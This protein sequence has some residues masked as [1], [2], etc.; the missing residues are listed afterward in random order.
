MKNL[1]LLYLVILKETLCTLYEIGSFS[2]SALDPIVAISVGRAHLTVVTSANSSGSKTVSLFNTTS[3]VSTVLTSNLLAPVKTIREINGLNILGS[4]YYLVYDTDGTVKSSNLSQ[5]NYSWLTMSPDNV[6]VANFGASPTIVYEL[7]TVGNDCKVQEVDTLTNS[8]VGIG[9]LYGVDCWE[10][11]YRNNII[12]VYVWDWICQEVAL[13]IFDALART[14][15]QETWYGNI[16]AYRNQKLE[17]SDSIFSIVNGPNMS[18][19]YTSNFSLLCNVLFNETIQDIKIT[20][21]WVYVSLSAEVR[22]YNP[23]SCMLFSI[24]VTTGPMRLFSQELTASS[25]YPRLLTWPLNSLSATVFNVYDRY[26]CSGGCTS[27]ITNYTL[28]SNQE[29]YFG[30]LNNN[31]TLPLG[32]ILPSSTN[33]TGITVWGSNALSS[34]FIRNVSYCAV[35]CDH[36]CG[37]CSH[38]HNECAKCHRHRSFGASN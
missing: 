30:S 18:V 7:V 6:S 1:T 21:Q 24:T 4:N 37:T 8:S 29:C 11:V 10:V 33:T 20:D 23:W 28:S 36:K 25:V 3:N 35:Y 32:P 12:Y 31:F 17:V 13:F 34:C 2:L 38:A 19:F 16:P 9:Y 5:T 27:C 22:H 15:I 14:Q 26:Q